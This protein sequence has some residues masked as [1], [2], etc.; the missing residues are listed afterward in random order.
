M[1]EC[2][3]TRA[4]SEVK[5]LQTTPSPWN[6]AELSVS[7]FT[8]VQKVMVEDGAPGGE[9]D[10]GLI[11]RY[12]AGSEE[13][14]NRLVLRHQRRAV[15]L[16]YRFLGNY[17]DACDVAQEAFLRVHRHLRRFRGQSSFKTWLYKIVLNLSRNK[18]R[19]KKRTGEFGRISIDNPH[20][21]NPGNPMEIPD[22]SLSVGQE[23]RRREIRSRIQEALSRLP[24]NHREILVLRHM[25]GLS[26]SDIS[27]MLGCAEGTIKSRLHRARMEIRKLLADMIES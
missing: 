7:N 14:F 8:D 24:K 6:M 10:S 2:R 15:N 20:P 5:L 3:L 16:A 13:A 26:Y 1:K 21:D 4:A 22:M 27:G 11:E 9:C 19:R 23:I 17:E 12:L 18:Y 25:E